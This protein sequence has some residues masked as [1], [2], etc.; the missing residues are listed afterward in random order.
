MENEDLFDVAFGTQ[1]SHQST[2]ALVNSI[3]PQDHS[4]STINN[5]N[6][7]IDIDNNN[8]YVS[9]LFKLRQKTSRLSYLLLH[10]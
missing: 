3:P 7:N 8:G 9:Y 4:E 10:V 5:N 2:P 6:N 1:Q